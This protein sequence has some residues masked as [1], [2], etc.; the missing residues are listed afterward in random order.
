MQLKRKV[1]AVNRRPIV[2]LV[3]GCARSTTALMSSTPTKPPVGPDGKVVVSFRHAGDAPILKQ[4]KFKLLADVKFC[5][6]V[7]LL[8]GHL[9]LQ[10]SDSLFLFCNSAFA[11]PP[12]E[13]L[14]DVARCFHVD[15]VL[16]LNYCTTPAWG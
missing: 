8:R 6:V 7:E 15:G 5:T 9:K 3:L 13:I 12:D 16:I 11:P 1:H 2:L 14:G 10:P 4:S